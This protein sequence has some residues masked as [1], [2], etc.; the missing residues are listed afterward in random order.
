MPFLEKRVGIIRTGTYSITFELVWLVPVVISFFVDAP[1]DGIRGSSAN[2]AIL[3]TG[4]AIS[5]IGLWSFDLAQVKVLQT[6]LQDHPRRNSITALQYSLCNIF[7][8]LK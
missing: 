6:T 1:P 4:M 8:L 5:R 3:F 7:D 2:S